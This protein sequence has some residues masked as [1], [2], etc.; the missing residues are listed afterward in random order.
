MTLIIEKTFPRTLDALVSQFSAA[1]FEGAR[2][3]AW[4]FDDAQDRAK[5]QAAF[6]ANGIEAI[7]RSA[8]KPLVHFFLEEAERPGEIASVRIGYPVI[9]GSERRFLLES[10]PLS[11]LLDGAEITFDA[12]SAAPFTYDVTIT[13][14]DGTRVETQVFAPNR[15]HTDPAGETAISP[16]GWLRVTKGTET[17]TDEALETDIESLF[18]T[19]I[20]AVDNHDWG[21][22]EPYFEELNIRAEV[23]ARDVPLAC[24]H[25]TISLAEA[26]HEDL[27]FSLLEIFQKKSGRPRGDRGLK[28]GQIVPEILHNSGA[29]SLRIETRPLAV[30]DRD[31][32]NAAIDNAPHALSVA[33][34]RAELDAVGGKALSAQSRADR[35]L[36]ARYV[37]GSD[38]AVIISG[39]QHAN[40]TSGIIGALRAA[41]QLAQQ[42]GAHFVIS[43]LENPDGYALHGRL[44]AI[45][46]SHMHHA[47]RYTGFGN[48]LEYE[49][50]AVDGK[51]GYER[52]IR[53]QS[54][55]VCNAQLHVNLH[56]YPAHEWTRPFSGY[57]PRG[58]EMWTI[59]KGFFLILRHHTDWQ[60]Q[61]EMLIDRV[62]AHL[63]ENR[64]LLAFNAEQIALFTRH[65]GETGFTMVNGFPC[66]VSVDDRH[67]T[68]LTLI[69]E[70]PDETIEDD[71]FI[72]AH[73]AQME[74]VLGAYTA[75][76]EIVAAA[77]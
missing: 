2:L 21:Q 46:K 68:P 18:H 50:D 44:T 22:T 27:Y 66:L 57:V 8:Y 15:S 20:T 49:P 60:E 41:R 42:P 32:P 24:G 10:Y 70:Y 30:A 63:S 7:I 77:D 52:A 55:A 53:T 36:D 40:E 73:T 13:Y 17:V 12:G 43:P 39:G 47:A 5:A 74:T 3:E 16:A 6:Q 51:P 14:R 56:G 4:V 45:H 35:R 25:E 23:A 11:A 29:L 19:A 33:Q 28:P 71:A 75:W 38:P 54:Q 34:I 37:A 58:F 31:M 64:K 1:P 72:D 76:K 69:T 48:D 59:P 62:T 65:A 9:E 67:Q 26:L 61:A